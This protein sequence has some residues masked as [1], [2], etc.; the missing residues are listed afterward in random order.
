MSASVV[1]HPT[2][3]R[4]DRW[5]STPI[6]SSTGEG[7]R[8]SDAQALPEWAAMPA[9]SRPEQHGLGL[10]AVD[11][12]AHEVGEAV[13]RDRRRPRTPSSSATAAEH[14]VGEPAGCAPTSAVGPVAIGQRGGRRRRA[15]PARRRSRAR[16]AGPAPGR[17][18]RSSGRRAAGPGARAARRCPGG[19]PNLWPL[20]DSRSAPS[21]VEGDRDVADGLRP[22]RRGRARR[23]RGSA[24]DDLGAPAGAVPTSWLPHCT[25][26]SAVS[27]RDGGER[28]RR[29]R[30]GRGGRRRRRSPIR[31]SRRRTR[32]SASRTA[33]CSTADTTTWAGRSARAPRP[34]WRRRSPRWRRW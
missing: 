4:S 3:M 21:V 28:P 19:P 10:D 27:G 18:R 29:D 20:T 22:R 30:C 7:S 6:A 33:E 9:W 31:R 17:R 24:A 11:A 5:A 34:R 26:T 25:C 13:D 16:P 1:D 15:R 14:A 32:R 12:E 23:G 2:E 8:A